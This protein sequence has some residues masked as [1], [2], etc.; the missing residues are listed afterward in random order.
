MALV[1][2]ISSMSNINIRFMNPKELN[3]I[4]AF[5]SAGYFED[6]FFKWVVPSDTERLSIVAEYY[7][8]YLEADG[9]YVYVA[10]ENG[11]VVGASVWLPHDV[12]PA[13]YDDID[14]AAGA[15]APNFRAVADMSHESE[16][17]DTHFTQLVG[18]V[19][20]QAQRG[21]GIGVA[22]LKAHLDIMDAEGSPTYL[23]ASTPFHGGGVYGKF[24][25]TLYG[26]LLRFS[27]TAVLYPLWRPAGGKS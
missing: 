21:R 23:E 8:V 7:K 19:V 18:F 14:A 10:E 4:A 25:Y 5:I 16:P 6:I 13:I 1:R 12:N 24:G 26:E 22:L 20:D 17:K 15:F 27:P 3:S 2:G 11:V 9:A